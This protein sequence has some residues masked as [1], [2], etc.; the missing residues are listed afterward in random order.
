MKPDILVGAFV[1]GRTVQIPG[2]QFIE[3]AMATLDKEKFLSTSD[4]VLCQAELVRVGRYRL[5]QVGLLSFDTAYYLGLRVA[6][7][8]ASF[9]RG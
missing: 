8:E 4:F 2:V 6:E 7:I 3:M 5:R 9:R 1:G